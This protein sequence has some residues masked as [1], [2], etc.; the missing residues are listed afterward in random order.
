M[1]L[2]YTLL[3]TQPAYGRQGGTTAL[4][5]ANSVYEAGHQLETVFFYLDGV[6]H[7]NYLLSP[8]S[9]EINLYARWC[10]LAQRSGCS[11]LVCVSAAE[12]RGVI[13]KAHASLNGWPH[14]NLQS[15]FII[16]GLAELSIAM[17]QSDRVVQL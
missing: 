6:S 5:F 8:A 4:R 16:A 17:L 3:V 9:D 12:R 15:P 2:R 7:A 11:L 13:G 14:Y 1:T 10:A